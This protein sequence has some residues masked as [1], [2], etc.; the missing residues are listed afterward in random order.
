MERVGSGGGG[1]SWTPQ[2]D[3]INMNIARLICKVL[4]EKGSKDDDADENEKRRGHARR[5][6]A[7][8]AWGRAGC[9]GLRTSVSTFIYA[10]KVVCQKV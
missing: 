6:V 2:T 4:C 10:A 1:A 3:I 9:S 7:R 5:S 8:G